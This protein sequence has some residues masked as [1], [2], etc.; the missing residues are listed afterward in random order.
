[1]NPEQVKESEAMNNRMTR[2]VVILGIVIV[3]AFILA[4]D[5]NA[6]PGGTS[7]EGKAEVSFTFL[8]GVPIACGFGAV[9]FQEGQATL[10][11]DEFGSDLTTDYM[12]W[13]C[14]TDD[15]FL[16][17]Y[18]EPGWMVSTGGLLLGKANDRALRSIGLV[19]CD[20]GGWAEP[21]SYQDERE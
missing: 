13:P 19:R 8:P 1:M 16:I 17:L 3:W 21:T 20:T 9:A 15:C 14:G 18:D 7:W 6:T 10:N 4:M 12:E 11:G 2:T 5:A